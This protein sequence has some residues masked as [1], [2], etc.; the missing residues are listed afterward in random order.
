MRPGRTP[1]LSLTRRA[2]GTRLAGAAAAIGFGQGAAAKG[3]S[4]PAPALD[5]DLRDAALRGLALADY[6]GDP[7]T[8]AAAKATIERLSVTDPSRSSTRIWITLDGRYA[9]VWPQMRPASRPLALF[10]RWL[11]ADQVR[12]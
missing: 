5:P 4:D 3:V 1:P 8:A 2:L 10:L 9:L 12:G 7:V 11:R 6:R